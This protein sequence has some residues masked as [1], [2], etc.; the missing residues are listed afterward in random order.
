MKKFN[1]I[2][3]PWHVGHQYELAKMPFIGQYDLLI[4]PYR[5]WGDKSRPMPDN[6]KYVTH[7]EKGKYDF[8]ILHIDQQCIGSKIGK[9]ILYKEVNSLIQDIPKIVIN[10]MVPLHD[11]FTKEETIEKTKELIGDNFMIVNTYKAKEMWG[12]GYPVI[13]GMEVDEWESNAKEPRATIFVSPAGMEKA[14]Q[15]DI[16]QNTISQL[17]EWGIR[18][19]WI[20]QDVKFN[21]FNEYRDWLSRSLIYLNLTHESPRPRSRTEAMLSGCCLITNKHQDADMFIENGVNGF[22]VDED[23][24]EV[25]TLVARLLTVDCKLAKEVGERGREFARK[26]FCS[27]KFIDQWIEVLKLNGLWEK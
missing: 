26:E 24:V 27:Q 22:L 18:F 3:V 12:W 13:H 23:P 15:R 7:Y 8:A 19:Y 25:A 21:N 4:N 16:L 6:M 11:T 9:G 10:H 1:V 17:R 14:Y 2:G 20:G 5:V